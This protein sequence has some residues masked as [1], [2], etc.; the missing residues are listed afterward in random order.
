MLAVAAAIFGL[1]TLQ[2]ERLCVCVYVR[3]GGGAVLCCHAQSQ[4]LVLWFRTAFDLSLN[5]NKPT[6]A[7]PFM[8]SS[9]CFVLPSESASSMIAFAHTP[10]HTHAHPLAFVVAAS[11]TINMALPAGRASQFPLSLPSA[12]ANTFLTAAFSFF[13]FFLV[14]TAQFPPKKSVRHTAQSKLRASLPCLL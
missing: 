7:L 4:R 9:F 11:R 14:C 6:P 1:L 10:S 13:R 12:T 8:Q 5:F 2:A 3:G